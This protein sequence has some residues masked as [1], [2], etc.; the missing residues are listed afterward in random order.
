LSLPLKSGSGWRDAVSLQAPVDPPDVLGLGRDGH[1]VLVSSDWKDGVGWREIA[2]EAA[3]PI[4]P[5][6]DGQMPI[7]DPSTGR[8]IG[9]YAL[10][11]DSGR[12]TFFDPTD[13]KI[14]NAVVAAYPGQI[15]Q[16][17]SWSDDR[18]RILVRVDSPTDGPAFAIV[19]LD[20]RKASWL[21]GEYDGLEPEDISPV[22]PISFTAA[23][24]FKL[25]GYLTMPRGREA[26]S[27]PL[28]V[29]PHGGPQARDMPG[30]DWWAQAMAS[31]GYVVLQVNFRGSEGFGWAYLKAGF[32]QWGRKM[33]SDL[34]DGVRY[35][36]ARDVINPK[37]VCIVGASYGGY[38]ALVG[39]T[40]ERGVYR[41]AVSYGGI[42]DLR[43]Q[44][45]YDRQRGGDWA[46]RYMN[47]F[48]GADGLDDPVLT[49]YSPLTHA[50]E[51]SAPI[52]LIHGKDDTVVPLVQSKAMADALHRAG[53]PVELIVQN[54]ADHWLSLGDTRLA[55][56]EA[57]MAFVEKNNPPD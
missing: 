6:S 42:S 10:V 53:K 13:Q 7:Q 51:A 25:T 44:V 4:R 14:W 35:L 48:I 45:A 38:A 5:V 18:R 26:K 49:K 52:L 30:F 47:R 32:G 27:L 15:V 28:I 57:A 37:R 40:L 20:A 8:L 55:M 33:Q 39:A 43:R 29:F 9:K 31:R 22:K 23:D 24:G 19:D 54:N 2:A 50:A 1:S 46:M 12:Y 56:L 41:C 11:G 21:G 16:F 3:S 36:A 17:R 34:S